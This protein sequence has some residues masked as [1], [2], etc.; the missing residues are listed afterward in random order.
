MQDKRAEGRFGVLDVSTGVHATRGRHWEGDLAIPEPPEPKVRRS[1][2]LSHCASSLRCT[3]LRSGRAAG[4]AKLAQDSGRLAPPTADNESLLNSS[5]GGPISVHQ[6]E[7]VEPGELRYRDTAGRL[8]GRRRAG[9][10]QE[11]QCRLHGWKL[12]LRC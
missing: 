7:Y 6:D 9:M 3:R 1:C 4:R 5:E 11:Q 12:G 8:V 10:V 2:P